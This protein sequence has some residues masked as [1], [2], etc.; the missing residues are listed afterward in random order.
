MSVLV[1]GA[2]G[3]LGRALGPLLP[4]AQRRGHELDITDRAALDAHDW[5]GTTAIVNAA[6]WTAVD[7]AEQPD[8][9]LAA[10]DVNVNGTANL[11]FHARRLDIPFVHVSTDYVLRGDSEGE[12]PAD[13]RLDPQGMYGIGKAAGEYAARIAPRHYVVRTSWVFGDGP[14]FVRT[15]RRLAASRPQLTVVDDQYGR[16]TYAGDLAAALVGLLDGRL[17]PGTYH[18]TGSGPVVSWAGFARQI[19]AD[20]NCEVVPVTSE[21]YRAGAPATAPRPANS[22]L[23]AGPLVLR[24]WRE[25]LADYLEGEQP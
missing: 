5:A 10:W 24:D 8:S 25:A 12:A 7:A 6:A 15:M 13:A 20:T 19:L 11:A 14:N 3:Q 1:T 9:L 22:A 21:Q 4:D 18:A 16:P 2:N 23:A 17:P